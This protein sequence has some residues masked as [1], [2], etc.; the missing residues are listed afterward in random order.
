MYG[1]FGA[2]AFFKGLTPYLINHL[3]HNVEI[4]GN[5]DSEYADPRGKYWFYFT[6]LLW[7][8][9]N[10]L[11]VRMQCLD[12]PHSKFRHAVVDMFK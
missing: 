6:M 5:P 10:I 4:F 7:N 3:L 12:Y 2:F 11:V 8:P 9:L 1:K